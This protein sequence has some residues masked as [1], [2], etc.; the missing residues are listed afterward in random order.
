MMFLP[1]GVYIL[2]GKDG[3]YYTGFT[4]NISRRLN[5]HLNGEVDYTK[6]RL[7]IKIIHISLFANKQL[8]YNFERYLKS[9]S[10]KAFTKRHLI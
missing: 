1:Y 8:A 5:E 4:S 6:N 3:S 10:G 2:E 9:S 7:P